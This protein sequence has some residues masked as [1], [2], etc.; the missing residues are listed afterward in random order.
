MCYICVNSCDTK[1]I[2][3][4]PNLYKMLFML[5]TNEL[6]I[7]NINLNC[8]INKHVVHEVLFIY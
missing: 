7:I 1:L 3:I 5:N 4:N 6:I 8:Q 2:G